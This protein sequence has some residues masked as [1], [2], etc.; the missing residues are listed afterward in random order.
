MILIFIALCLLAAGCA[1]HPDSSTEHSALQIPVQE[2]WRAWLDSPGGEIAFG[3]ELRG[4]STGQWQAH[5]ING[6]ERIEVG[7]TQVVGNRI[8]LHLHPYDSKIEAQIDPEGLRMEG[9]WTRYRSEEEMLELP[10]HAR[11]N[12]TERFA[13][14]KESS[15]HLSDSPYR[16]QFSSD[17]HHAIGHFKRVPGSHRVL[18][19]FETTLG[20]Y[21][22][23]EGVLDG[24]EL[25][26]SC[27]DGAHAFLFKAQVAPD[28]SLAG[29]FWSRDSWHETWTGTPDP[30]VTMPD[31]FGLTELR[32][33]LA[34]GDF[35]YPDPDGKTWRL[36]DP[37]F[38]GKARLIVL[39]GTW[40]PNCKDQTEFLVELNKR[41]G[42]RGLSILAL[43]FEFGDDKARNRRIVGDYARFHGAEFPILLAG[44]ADKKRASQSFA[45]VDAVRAYPTTLFMDE[46]GQVQ[47][48]Y[49]GFSGP[50][51]G[52]SHQRL[53][54]GFVEQIE[55]L[56][57]N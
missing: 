16:V 43:A 50:A 33:G 40:C 4:D 12:Q 14:T 48:I 34:L 10:F 51:T 15:G 45:W 22:F 56:L 5:L 20:D 52:A 26:L 1:I 42:D 30:S 17:K 29:E 55:A 36:D 35:A 38:A 11:V 21:R 9:R 3:L 39:F 54:E 49:T 8:A 18:G 2:T 24:D 47:S 31:A 41:Y 6:E 57:V 13:V 7:E 37:A 28:G 19:T 23:L 27:F 46:S 53:R 44:N 32:E 25:I